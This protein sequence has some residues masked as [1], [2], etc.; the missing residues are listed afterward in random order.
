MKKTIMVVH[1]DLMAVFATLAAV[2]PEVL[3]ERVARG[4]VAGTT[5]KCVVFLA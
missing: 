5:T 3:D 2:V 1:E 4:D